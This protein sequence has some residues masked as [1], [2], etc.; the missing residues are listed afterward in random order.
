MTHPTALHGL[1][2]LE[3]LHSEPHERHLCMEAQGSPGLAHQLNLAARFVA[4]QAAP[5]PL[6]Y[7]GC[8][9]L[10]TMTA[11]HLPVTCFSTQQASTWRCPRQPAGA[12]P[13]AVQCSAGSLHQQRPVG[14][15]WLPSSAP[16]AAAGQLQQQ[17]ADLG[18]ACGG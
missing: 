6:P 10:F 8:L 17:G 1:E 4:Q 13:T 16:A 15:Q 11:Q 12:C 7:D 5:L 14:H 18:L 9:M 2:P 3:P